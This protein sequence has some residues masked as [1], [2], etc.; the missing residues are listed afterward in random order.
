MDDRASKR[1]HVIQVR[2]SK[3]DESFR[4]GKYHHYRHALQQ[5]QLK[6]STIH[7]G[8]NEQLQERIRDV[9]ESRDY[10]LVELALWEKFQIERA[11][12][13][14]ETDVL[15]ANNEHDDMVKLVKEKLYANLE[16]QI[17][18]LK[19]DKILLDMANS[20][21]YSMEAT[22][23]DLH[24]N[25]RS[26][27]KEFNGGYLSDR[28]T[29][30]RRR[31]DYGT[32]GEESAN[33]SGNNTSSRRQTKPSHSQHHSSNEETDTAADLSSLLFA[34]KNEKVNTRHSSKSYAAPLGL[35]PEEITDDLT[36]LRGVK[37]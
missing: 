20:H 22:F 32:N 19:E 23:H 2:L 8:T 21:S 36:L 34:P 28:R 31:Q 4:V 7:Q 18:Q 17:K 12:H 14:F 33:D 25:T 35:K 6:L 5:L 13:E 9:E 15:K 3:L 1:Q 30:L 26:S 11:E 24:K 10:E 29:G 27:T 16:R 37:R